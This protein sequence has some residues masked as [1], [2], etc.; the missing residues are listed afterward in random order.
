MFEKKEKP[1]NNEKG[2]DT[3]LADLSKLFDIFGL[4]ILEA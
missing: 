2:N 1:V 3:L 4:E